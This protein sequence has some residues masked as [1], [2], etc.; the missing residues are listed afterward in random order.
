ME[1]GEAGAPEIAE[2][3][4]LLETSGALGRARDQARRMAAEAVAELGPFPDGPARRA[5]EAVPGFLISRDH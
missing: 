4:R 2:L 1:N 3:T 5:L